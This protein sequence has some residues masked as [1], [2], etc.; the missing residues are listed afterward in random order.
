MEIKC[1][2][3]R[4]SLDNLSSALFLGVILCTALATLDWLRLLPAALAGVILPLLPGTGHRRVQYVLWGILAAW[5]LL[6]FAPVLD[7]CRLLANRIF[8]RSAQM[9]S[10]EYDYFEASGGSPVEAVLWLSVLAGSLCALWGNRVSG[11]LCALHLLAMAYF[12]VTPGTA[13]L[14]ALAVAA[15]WSALPGQQRW[16]HGLL[17]AVLAAAIALAMT[18]LL[19]EPNEAV[20]AL[21]D[22]LRDVLAAAPVHREQTPVPT[23][24]PEP[25]IVPPPRTQRE[26]PDHGVREAMRSILFFLLSAL[27]LALLFIPAV[28]K[29]RAEKKRALARAGFDDPDHAAA[30]RAMYLYARRWRA[31]GAEDREIPPEVYAIWQEAAFS[32][33]TMTR[34][35]REA[36]HAYMK[37]T[38]QQVWQEADRKKRLAIRYRVCL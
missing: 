14:T 22:H 10:Y 26:Q 24:V 6:R 2:S 11:V 5:L 12:G 27:A 36:M 37:Q 25:E 29:D 19:P 20:S 9:Q 23:Q 1:T 31:L 15:L 34:A 7:G 4:R 17:V 8:L 30:I 13:W 28:I 35:Q 16:L 3:S 18:G 21:D 33:H 38:A 32:G